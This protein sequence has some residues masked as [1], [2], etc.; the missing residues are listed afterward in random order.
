[1]TLNE[2]KPGQE[3]RVVKVNVEGVTGQRLLDMGLVPGT[4]IR[5]VRNAPLVGPVDFQLRGYHV[6]MRHSEARGVEVILL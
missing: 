1:M 4:Q 3:C 2:L 5:V 6:S